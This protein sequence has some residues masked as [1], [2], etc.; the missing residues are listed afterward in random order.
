MAPR[1]P[2]GQ[3]PWRPMALRKPEGRGTRAPGGVRGRAPES[4]MLGCTA[5]GLFWMF[6]HLERTENTARLVEVSARISLTR[7]QDAEDEWGSALA[8]LGAREAF[9]DEHGRIDGPGVWNHLLR[10]AHPSCVLDPMARARTGARAVRTALTRETFEVVNESWRRIERALARP[11]AQRS[12]PAVLDLIRERAA[13]VRGTVR[14]TMMRDEASHFARLGTYVERADNAARILDVMY[15]VLLPS[16][17]LVGSRVDNAQRETILRS[18]S[19]HRS[20]VRAHGGEVTPGGD[21]ALPDVRPAHAP[22]AG[23]L[24][25]RA[26]GQLGPLEVLHNRPTEAGAMAGEV[27]RTLDRGDID[28][29]MEEGLH[30]T[31]GAFR[32]RN[33]A[34][35]SHIEADYGIY[36]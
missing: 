31:L 32:A 24:L 9:A 8:A 6:R 30:E 25:P 28:G 26:D 16:V 23:A 5:A 33:A 15:Y 36:G 35:A 3:G 2:E 18:V 14:R 13:L 11:V 10:G 19:A 1:K 22:L 34:I 12:L 17:R 7:W 4:P 27:R 20:Y 21:R 29:V